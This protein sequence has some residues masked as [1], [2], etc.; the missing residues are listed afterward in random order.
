[1]LLHAKKTLLAATCLLLAAPAV[2]S[3]V[4][5]TDNFNTLDATRWSAVTAG[6]PGGGTSVTVQN[7]ECRLQN[8]GHLVSVQ[9]FDHAVIGAYRVTCRW[10]F[11]DSSDSFMLN[12]RS[13]GTPV[14]TAF[15]TTA[16]GIELAGIMGPSSSGL[17]WR[18][19]QIALTPAVYSGPGVNYTVGSW[20]TAQITDLGN[21]IEARIDGPNGQWVG[22]QAAVL[23]DTT[24]QKKIAFYNREHSGV[25]H[26]CFLDDVVV[27]TVPT[28]P[29][30]ITNPATGNQYTLVPPMT[31][32]A[33]EAYA[34]SLGA[35]LCTIETA[36]EN[37]WVANN[38]LTLFPLYLGNTDA[39]IE[40]NWTTANGWPQAYANWGPNQPDNFNDQDY[41]IMVDANPI[42]GVPRAS[43]DDI[44]GS[45]ALFSVVERPIPQWIPYGA[46]CAGSNGTPTIA[47]ASFTSA[48]LPGAMISI[49]VAHLTLS[50]GAAIGVLS[51]DPT[52][53]SLAAIGMP[54]CTALVSLG[55]GWTAA[56]V[57]GG[58]ST[59]WQ[60]TLPN[61]PAIRGLRIFTQ[62]LSLDAT[63]GN[64]FGGVTSAGLE[65]RVGY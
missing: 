49:Q 3:Q 62:A 26:Q 28:T 20:Y 12:L 8:R 65:I 17:S 43:W 31:R 27:A 60:I 54:G 2:R 55:S 63:A 37:A 15:G 41:L 14:P 24:V 11:T 9:Q 53:I 10:R 18:G 25:Q 39:V 36:A 19:S 46:G 34:N 40:G 56:L 22:M 58:N 32:G 45:A 48:P 47:P 29:T 7:G 59:V 16:N 35:D 50:P 1:M 38:F 30:W 44:D 23:F 64:P 61:L 52:S 57:H 33:A 51:L 13:D 4:I 21:T 6:V 5:W 42:F